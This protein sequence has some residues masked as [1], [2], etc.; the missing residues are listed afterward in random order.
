MLNPEKRPEGR[1]KTN[2]VSA[3]LTLLGRMTIILPYERLTLRC[4]RRG[5][6]A[7]FPAR[8]KTRLGQLRR[9]DGWTAPQVTLGATLSLWPQNGQSKRIHTAASSVKCQLLPRWLADQEEG[10][11]YDAHRISK[12]PTRALAVEASL[13]GGSKN[14]KI[15]TAA[16]ARPQSRSLTEATSYPRITPPSVLQNTNIYHELSS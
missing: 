15:W 16:R 3:T 2:A 7:R 9:C 12:S 6:K 14:Y 4:C 13:P 10:A 11:S 5:F 8:Q 1:G